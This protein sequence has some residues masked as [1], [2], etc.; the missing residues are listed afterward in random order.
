MTGAMVRGTGEVV[1]PAALASGAASASRI[2]RA[3]GVTHAAAAVVRLRAEQLV[4]WRGW[5][6]GP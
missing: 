3:A 4:W 2:A 1:V 6:S 5:S